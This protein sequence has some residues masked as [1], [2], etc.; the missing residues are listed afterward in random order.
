VLAAF[1]SG[2]GG[3]L[4]KNWAAR[5]LTPAFVFWAAGLAAVWWST[6]G[7][8]VRDQGWSGALEA[9]ARP[10]EQ[11]A[12]VAQVVL[13]LGALIL[14]VGSA[15]AAERLTLPLL[16]LLEG[17]WARPAWLHRRLVDHRRSRRSRW[18]T[19][20][21]ALRL[22]ESRGDLTIAEETELRGLADEESLGPQQVERLQH[23]TERKRGLTA[24]EHAELA[25]GASFLR[26]TPREEPLGMPTRLGDILRAAE[27]RPYDKYG[28]DAV[29]CWFRLW[30]LLPTEEKTEIAQARLELDRAVRTWLWGA[31]FLVWTPWLWWAAVPIGLLV[32]VLA[33][34][35]SMLSAAVLFG[36]LVET[37]FDLHRMQLYDALHLPRPT[38]AADERDHGVQLSRLLWRGETD[39]AIV[40]VPPASAD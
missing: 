17:Y 28:L 26:G 20:V 4:A 35:I 24:A 32:P 19:R 25:R 10:L 7:D 9:T 30:M 34:Y 8:D 40:Y 29:V 13:V 11:L 21:E 14:L 22:T 1:W 18:S 15:L 38:S 2:L 6:H 31:L 37:S 12:T 23:L 39:P 16:K 5:I 3:E 33:Y 36:D 27:R